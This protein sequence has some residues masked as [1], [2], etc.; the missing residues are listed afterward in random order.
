MNARKTI[1]KLEKMT[2][3]LKLN[4]LSMDVNRASMNIFLL[5]ICLHDTGECCVH[6]H[7]KTNEI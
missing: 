5:P 6:Q 1:H 4:T 7:W 3:S 2:K